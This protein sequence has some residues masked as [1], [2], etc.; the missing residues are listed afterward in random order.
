MKY[1]FFGTEEQNTGVGS[2][3]AEEPHSWFAAFG[4]V[5]DFIFDE[6]DCDD[7]GYGGYQS[8]R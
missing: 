2:P 5:D 7:R 8:Q 6:N 1:D 4:D 3:K